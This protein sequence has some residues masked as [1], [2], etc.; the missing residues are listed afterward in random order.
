MA[1]DEK[2]QIIIHAQVF[3]QGQEQSTLTLMIEGIRKNMDEKI[4]ETSV[5]LTADTGFSSE[6]NMEYLFEEHIDAVIPSTEFSVDL[7]SGTC[8][9]PAGNEMLFLGDHFDGAR[10]KYSCFR[11]K[12]KGCRSCALQPRCMKK[13]LK[14]QG[15]YPF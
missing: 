10:G 9:C 6:A 4:F 8:I 14:D 3:G 11:G 15:R 7:K 12:L 13:A 1:A 2:H 5:V